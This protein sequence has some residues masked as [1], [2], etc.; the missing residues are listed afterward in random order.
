MIRLLNNEGLGLIAIQSLLRHKGQL[1]VLKCYLILPMVFDKKIR[2]YLK[3]KNVNLLSFQQFFVDKPELFIGFSNK[4]QDTLKIT[5]N[6]ILMGIEMGILEL[7]GKDLKLVD[8]SKRNEL[9]SV[10]KVNDIHKATENLS[11]V[12]S[13]EPEL[14]YGLVRIE[15]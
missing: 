11:I 2:T 12:L 4:Y 15:I 13:D 5:T 3:N 6:S 10:K 7:D 9:V 8:D 14:I 1:S